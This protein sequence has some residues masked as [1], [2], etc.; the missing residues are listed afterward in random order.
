MNKYLALYILL[1]ISVL[2]VPMAFADKV[3]SPENERAL[4]QLDDLLQ[5]ADEFAKAR[6]MQIEQLKKRLYNATNDEE[7]FWITK[8]IFD[9]YKI[10]DG[11]SA[12]LYGKMAIKV[13][14]GIN[15]PDLQNELHIV[16]SY[17]YAGIGLL[18]ES[19]EE[20]SKVNIDELSANA[21][22]DYMGQQIYLL[23]HVEQFKNVNPVVEQ[24][25]KDG[26]AILDSI[27]N[28]IEPTHPEYYYYIGYQALKD[29]ESAQKALD[30]IIPQLDNLEYNSQQDAKLLWV[31]A[32]LY[33]TVRNRERKLHYLTLSAITD[34]KIGNRE[35]ASLEEISGMMDSEGDLNRAYNYIQYCLQCAEK[36]KNR[37]RAL[38]I[39]TLESYISK[40]YQERFMEMQQRIYVYLIITILLA[41]ILLVSTIYIYRQRQKLA[42]S[43]KQIN[44]AKEEVTEKLSELSKAYS[45]LAENN[46]K[47]IEMSDELRLTN[48]KIAESDYVKVKCIGSI[49]ALC[50]Q[51]IN[52]ME[53][54]RRGFARQLKTNRYEQAMQMAESPE[55]SQKELKEFFEQFDSMFLSIYPDFVA[56]FN[57]LLRPEDA[58]VPKNP[59]GLNTELR[60]H[61]LIRLGILDSVSIAEILH[62]SVQTVYNKRMKVRN[63]AI[64]SKDNFVEI[65]KNLGKSSRNTD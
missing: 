53:D 24:M 10:F 20:L 37:V 15:R 13:A 45:Q 38:R 16:S 41:V 36:Y 14:D 64:V 4:Q 46:Q 30:T 6:E 54:S 55:Q 25:P 17:T 28:I 58:I 26:Q 22:V 34:M 49:I 50:S 57:A 27:V 39:A 51:Y 31:V 18:D 3:I 23:T 63:K 61:A 5:R 48:D 56:D 2:S 9:E 7:K 44:S 21:K 59:S 1:L 65:V 29:Q 12:L 11:D 47:L 42:K 35:I 52:K 60:I 33:S 43:N 32:R 8:D 40:K 62:C 19:Y